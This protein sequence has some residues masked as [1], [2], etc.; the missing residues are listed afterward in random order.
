MYTSQVM[1][2]RWNEGYSYFFGVRNGL[3]L[4]TILSPSRF[5]VYCNGLLRQLGKFREVP[6]L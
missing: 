6:G 2:M 1:Q 3:C 5:N 4:R